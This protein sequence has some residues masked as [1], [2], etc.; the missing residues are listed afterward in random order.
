V[1]GSLGAF[2]A[3]APEPATDADGTTRLKSHRDSEH[4]PGN[5]FH[6]SKSRPAVASDGKAFMPIYDCSVDDLS[7]ITP[8]CRIPI[9]VGQHGSGLGN[10][11]FKIEN[12]DTILFRG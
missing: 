9:Y 8:P 5:T 11:G 4:M 2:G 3:T 10:S 7:V 12:R 6:L 1:E